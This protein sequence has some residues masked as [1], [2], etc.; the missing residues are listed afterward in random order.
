[1]TNIH[2]DP[3]KRHSF[4]LIVNAK[5]ANPNGDPNDGNRPRTRHDGHGSISD[6]SV[7]RKVRDYISSMAELGYVTPEGKIYVNRGTMKATNDELGKMA[8]E[9]KKLNMSGV[10]ATKFVDVRLFGG[11]ITFQ[12]TNGVNLRGPVQVFNGNS[13]SV[14]DPHREAVVTP[15]RDDD[16]KQGSFGERW[17]VENAIYVVHG[18]YSPALAGYGPNIT[19]PEGAR[20]IG[21]TGTTAADLELLWA[22]LVNSYEHNASTR[23]DID[24]AALVVTT[25]DHPLGS[26]SR[27]SVRALIHVS[28]DGGVV[29]DEA[30]GLT[31]TIMRPMGDPYS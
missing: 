5:Y 21:R 17:R 2:T 28:P 18:D 30:E 12:G 15:A 23:G 10:I 13:L 29:V 4:A 31:T 24:V 25:H 19:T 1:M 16:K 9:D 3:A 20:A 27:D 11:L 7:K 8:S 14:I 26:A 6:V 22:G